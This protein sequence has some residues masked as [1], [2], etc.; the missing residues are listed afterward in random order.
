MQSR[1]SGVAP[2]VTTAVFPLAGRGTRLLPLT[3]AVPKEL[4]PVG[5][6][7][8]VEHAV[9]EAACSGIQRVVLVLGPGKGALADHFAPVQSATRRCAPEAAFDGLDYINTRVEVVSVM[10]PDSRGLGSAVLAARPIVGS[11]PF[12]VILA[13]D[14]IDHPKPALGQMLAARSSLASSAGLVAVMEVPRAHTVRYGV[15][16]GVAES[17]RMLRVSHLVEKPQPEHAPSTTAIV[18]RY[19]LPAS[20]FQ[21]L[22]HT[23]PG[24]DGEVQ[25][26]DA[27]AHLAAAGELVAYRFEG[28]RFD[29]G[30]VDGW[31]AASAHFARHDPLRSWSA[32][33]C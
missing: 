20:V 21:A 16:A 29:A 12:A 19:V 23:R 28:Q 10:Q 3:R 27:L 14:L 6:R 2:A 24:V 18:G 11:D 25:L 13:D 1:D 26:T 7:P 4:L 30:S 9:L 15:C 8:M 31:Q 17:A 32:D 5:A 33:A 22:E